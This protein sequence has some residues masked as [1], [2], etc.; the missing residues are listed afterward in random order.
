MEEMEWMSLEDSSEI[1]VFAENFSFNGFFFQFIDANENGSFEIGETYALSLEDGNGNDDIYM[2]TVS[3][4]GRFFNLAFEEFWEQAYDFDWDGGDQEF[5]VEGI[6][7][8][9]TDFAPIEGAEVI[10]DMEE[11]LVTMTDENGY[12]RIDLDNPGFYRV[13]SMADGYW[14]DYTMVDVGEDG[15]QLDFWLGDNDT[16]ALLQIWAGTDNWETVAY[17]ELESPQSPQGLSIG[18]WNGWDLI[19]VNVSWG[20]ADI[21]GY[22]PEYGEAYLHIEDIEPGQVYERAIYFYG[23]STGGDPG[24]LIAYVYDQDGY[25]IE[26]AEVSAWNDEYDANSMTDEDGHSIMELPPGWYEVTAFADGFEDG[27]GSV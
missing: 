11:L 9:Y 27:S 23:D 8:D 4:D 14:D 21:Y 18:D 1:L 15:S 12:Y 10:V 16:T 5:F 6:V 22:S 24:W 7:R 19:T 26:G 3:Y 2:L 20:Y 25:P 17:A 13:G